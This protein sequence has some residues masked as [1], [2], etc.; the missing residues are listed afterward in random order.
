MPKQ[1]P[2]P[3]KWVKGKSLIAFLNPEDKWGSELPAYA[4]NLLWAA[5]CLSAMGVF[6]DEA[7]TRRAAALVIRKVKQFLAS[8]EEGVYQSEESEVA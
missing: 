6:E 8:A 1:A 7:R 2:R 3:D 5:Q 4:Q